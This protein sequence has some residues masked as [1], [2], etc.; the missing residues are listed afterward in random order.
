MVSDTEPESLRGD[1]V[2]EALGKE[3]TVVPHT[4]LDTELAE[5]GELE[6]TGAET[7]M[8]ERLAVVAGGG[9]C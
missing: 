2:D 6:E 1:R 5:M 4:A 3:R 8:A 9:A 7:C